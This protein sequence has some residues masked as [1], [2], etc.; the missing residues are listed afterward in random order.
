MSKIQPASLPSATDKAEALALT[1]V[2]PQTVGRLDRYVA[3]LLAWQ[4]KTNLVAPST[5]PNLWTRHVAD[6]LQ[7]LDLAPSAKIWVDLGSGGGFPGVV[8]ACALA[9]MPDANVHLV[10]RNAKKA[11]FLREAVRITSAAATVHLAGIGDIVDRIGSS[12]DC[13]TARALAPLHQL[14]GFAE[15]FVRNGAKALFLK[16]QDVEAELTEATKYWNIEPRLHSSRTG[17]H[18]WIVELD[19]IERRDHSAITHGDRA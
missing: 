6:S 12:V 3:L 4:A 9:G 13:V 17:G 16:G 19:R 1:P 7:L 18:G 5:L 11:A 8:L 14:V 15:P 2:S 10:E